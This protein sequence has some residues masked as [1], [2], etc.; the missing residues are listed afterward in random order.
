[1]CQTTH[2]FTIRHS[3]DVHSNYGNWQ[4]VSGVGTDPRDYRKFNMIKQQ[5]DYDPSGEYVKTWVHEL[6]GLLPGH[7]GLFMPWEM[8]SAIPGYPAPI[9]IEPEWSKFSSLRRGDSSQSNRRSNG[10]RGKGNHREP[11]QQ[12]QKPNTFTPRKSDWKIVITRRD[13][14]KPTE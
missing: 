8:K 14:S 10:E 12:E 1:L 2:P 9:L 5:K 6:E 7:P 11:I 3:T 4:Y 13:P